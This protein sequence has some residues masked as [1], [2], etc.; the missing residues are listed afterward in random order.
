MR[1]LPPLLLALLALTARAQDAETVRLPP[2]STDLKRD[3]SAFPYKQM[4]TVLAK[5]AR[6]GEGLV[7]MDFRIDAEKAGMPAGQQ[8]VVVRSDEAD[9]PIRIGDDGVFSMPVLPETEAATADLAT[10]VPKGKLNVRGTLE[11]N[12]TP[13]QLDMAKVRQLMRVARRLREEM[14]PW[15]LRPLFPRIQAVRVC[16][17]TPTWELEWRENGQL[18]GL[19]L[20]VAA[21]ERDPETKKDAP[22][23][24]CALLT[25]EERWPDAARLIPPPGTRI[26]VKY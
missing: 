3:A 6:Y 22:A 7:R 19:P 18:L 4:N 1:L 25:G 15:Y 17:S 8:R 26:S 5:L 10:N 12:V 24:P 20:P 2:V 21:G 13:E 11:L 23:K 16:S 14:L 9:Y